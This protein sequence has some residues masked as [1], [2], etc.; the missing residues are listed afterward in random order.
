MIYVLILFVSWKEFDKA[1]LFLQFYLILLLTMYLKTVK[2]I[3]YHLI[4][5]SVV[6]DFFANDIVLC[7]TSWTKLKKLLKKDNNWA[8]HNEMEFGIKKCATMVIK[9]KTPLFC[10]K[11]DPTFYLAGQ[12]LSITECYTYLGIPFC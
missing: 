4:I 9:P 8:I 11:K 10:N 3:E 6:V 7:S 1:A 2:S 12:L 5:S